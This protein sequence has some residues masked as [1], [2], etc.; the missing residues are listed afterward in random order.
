MDLIHKCIDNHPQARAQASEI[1]KRLAE[2]ILQ[3]PP[4]F[5]N[6]SEMQ[7]RIIEALEQR[8]DGIVQQIDLEV[9]KLIGQT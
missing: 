8:K 1:V 5:I 3:Y 7:R 2:M 6:G 4:S 9:Q